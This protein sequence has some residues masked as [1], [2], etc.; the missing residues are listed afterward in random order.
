MAKKQT[1]PGVLTNRKA[2][3]IDQA[4]FAAMCDVV[5]WGE[6]VLD[7]GAGEGRYV[8]EFRKYGRP[9]LGLDGNGLENSDVA[10]FD[11]TC[12]RDPAEVLYGH[13]FFALNDGLNDGP[14]YTM[15]EYA[16]CIE[17]G[18][19]IPA[20][21]TGAF[22]LSVIELF[23]RKLILSWATPGQRGRGHV[24]C[25][26]PEVVAVKAKHYGLEINQEDTLQ[27]RKR[28][29]GSWASKAMVLDNKNHLGCLLPRD[30]THGN[31]SDSR[32]SDSRKEG[33]SR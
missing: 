25:L 4:L 28:A 23:S 13:P 21:K 10:F 15:P 26:L 17:V 3:P 5:P 14:G 11:L 27:L 32:K 8:R 29:G 12:Q 18:E 30:F 9:S 16:I 7:I 33:H 20:D 19:H 1:P 6:R 22:F 24:N 31:T 2:K